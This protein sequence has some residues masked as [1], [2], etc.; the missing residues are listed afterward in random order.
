MKRED[1][2]RLR[3]LLAK[4][5][6]GPWRVKTTG[7][8]GN[9]IEAQSGLRSWE[10]DDGMRSVC[11][12]QYCGSSQNYYEQKEVT[13]ATGELI[14]EAVNALPALLALAETVMDAPESGVVLYERVAG[15]PD[16]YAMVNA[17]VELAGQ[18]VRLVAAPDGE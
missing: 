5:T 3:E 12:F 7:N 15:S 6:P 13:A 9:Q 8:I 1:V 2:V 17:P 16:C 10:R 14:A 18:R 4:A 11:G